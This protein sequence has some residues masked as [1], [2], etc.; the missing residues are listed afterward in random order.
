MIFEPLYFSFV[1]KLIEK[2]ACSRLTEHMDLN[3]LADTYQSAYRPLHSTESAHI[4]VKNDIMFL[5]DANKS[6]L[7]VLLDLSAAFD[8]IDHNILISRLSQQICVKGPALDWFRSC[9]ADWSTQVDIAGHL[10]EPII[11]Q[12]GLPQGSVVGPVGYTVYTL[13]V[14]DI[15][16]HHYVSPHV[17]FDPKVICII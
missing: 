2:I 12:F 9:L 7:F 5:L 16:N 14:G 15:A 17:S 11:S 1:G 6:V 10:S 3:N 8:T 13:P 4:K